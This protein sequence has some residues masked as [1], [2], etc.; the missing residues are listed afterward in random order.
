MR[1]PTLAV[2]L[3][4]LLMATGLAGQEPPAD[5]GLQEQTGVHLVQVPILATDRQGAPVK[6]LRP[7]EIVVEHRG[8]RMRVAYLEH[9]TVVSSAARSDVRLVVH[10][11][12][13]WNV[14]AAGGPPVSRYVVFFIDVQ[15]DDKLRRQ[16][17]RDATLGIVDGLPPGSAVAVASFDGSLNLELPF[18]NDR[19]AVKTALRQAWDRPG[20]PRLELAS[21]MRALLSQVE[22]CVRPGG[23]QFVRLPDERC[24]QDVAREHA[25]K[26]RP[27]AEAYLDAL[28]SMVRYLSGLDAYKT[29][30]AASHGTEVNPVP[31]ILEAIRAVFGNIP[32]LADVQGYL[33]PGNSPSARMDALIDLAVRGR[34]VFHFVDRTSVPADDL[35]ASRAHALEPGARPMAAAHAAAQA[36]MEELAVTT[37]GT[38]RSSPRL[39]DGLAAALAVQEAGYEVGYYLDELL[40]AKGLEKVE[41]DCT[42]RGVKISHRRGAYLPP[43]AA[44]AAMKGR[45]AIARTKATPDT[46]QKVTRAFQIAADPRQIGYRMAE[47]EAQANF[48]V[49][50]T[51]QDP[52]GHALADSYHFL[53]HAYPRSMWEKKDV[54]DVLLNGFFEAP[55]GSY[56][57]VAVFRNTD[58]GWEG[59]LQ[60]E[61]DVPEEAGAERN[62]R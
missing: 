2:L 28:Q 50:I 57:L 38:F 9:S 59:R 6:D 61:L 12:G 24:L 52:Q 56:A 30:Y 37:G 51:L 25:E 22:D 47:K 7:E 48:T 33:G 35:G 46:P 60:R 42:R 5:V 15:N 21:Q 8:R 18:S 20:Q 3:L 54:G 44:A 32:Q 1:G 19:E 31:T 4:P 34:V 13:N 26:E 11:P 36:D 49:H 40:S 10:A 45:I 62:S 43:S 53:N 14:G 23:T 29:V 27:G 55:P 17:A 39:Q 41:I 58:T 16:E